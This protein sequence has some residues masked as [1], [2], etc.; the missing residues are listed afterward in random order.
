MDDQGWVPI[1]LIA[2]FNKVSFFWVVMVFIYLYDEFFSR[3][4]SYA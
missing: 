2:S 3:V 4:Y 1:K